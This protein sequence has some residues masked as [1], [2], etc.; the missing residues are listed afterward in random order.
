MERDFPGGGV[1]GGGGGGG[2]KSFKQSFLLFSA[3]VLSI[4]LHI[5]IYVVFL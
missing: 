3:P 1:E 5:Y 2:N 4:S